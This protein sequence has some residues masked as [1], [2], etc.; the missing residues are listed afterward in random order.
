[1]RSYTSIGFLLAVILAGACSRTADPL[2]PLASLTAG[3]TFLVTDAAVYEFRLEGS[4]HAVDFDLT[5]RNPLRAAVAVPAC[6]TPVRPML[7]KQVEGEWVH[8]FSPVELMCI[9]RPLVIPA[10]ATHTFHY[11]LRADAYDF[12]RWPRA[13]DGS[14]S[15]IYRLRWWVGLH[16]RRAD[17]G[18]GQPLPL[19]YV[20][21]NTFEL[22][23][24]SS[25]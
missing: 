24:E 7:E 1:M 18:V 13:A 14:L 5:Y 21:S 17:A 2:G 6:H 19:A 22:R 12:D 11:Q 25:E 16:D 23:T 10:R 3:E 8:A 15:G 20:V 9:T 4:F